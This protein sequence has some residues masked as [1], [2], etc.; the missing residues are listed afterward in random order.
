MPTYFFVETTGGRRA[1]ARACVD[2]CKVFDT[3]YDEFPSILRFDGDAKIFENGFIARAWIGPELRVNYAFLRSSLDRSP[4]WSMFD[5]ETLEFIEVPD[6]GPFK[7][8]AWVMKEP[9]LILF[10]LFA[11]KG[12]ADGAPHIAKMQEMFKGSASFCPLVF[13]NG[14]VLLAATKQPFK[15]LANRCD[16]QLAKFQD[17]YF[18]D[19]SQDDEDDWVADDKFHYFS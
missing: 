19:V 12:D 1:A 10:F 5:T 17:W 8:N 3:V 6:D 13:T 15:T 11:K 16:R 4:R 14:A 9:R 2:F 18:S 7:N